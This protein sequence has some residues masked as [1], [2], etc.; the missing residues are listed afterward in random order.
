MA[1]LDAPVDSISVGIGADTRAFR[2]ELAD[3]ERLTRSFASTLGD[4]FVGVAVKGRDVGD[5]VQG[6]GQR[7]SG[8]AL[9]LALKPVEQGISGFFSSLL[10]TS[11]FAEGG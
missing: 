2:A 11:A 5:V 3:T 1:T 7:L 4:A 9:N 8:L 10:G 6:I